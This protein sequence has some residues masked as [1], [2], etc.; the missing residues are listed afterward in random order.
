MGI[1]RN[2]RLVMLRSEVKEDLSQIHCRAQKH[3]AGRA[4]IEPVDRYVNIVAAAGG[5]QF[6]GGV[7]ITAFSDLLLK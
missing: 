4:K 3:K 5:V 7:G 2:Q 6:A 1:C